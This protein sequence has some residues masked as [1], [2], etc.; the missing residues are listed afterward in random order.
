[1]GVVYMARNK[2]NG[3]AYVGITTYGFKRRMDRHLAA[4]DKGEHYRFADAIRKYGKDAWDWF[5][6][7]ESNDRNLLC[8]KEIEFIAQYGYYNATLG[9]DG[10]FGL[11]PS[12]ETKAKISAT[13]K[14][15][16]HSEER[17]RHIGD[18]QRGKPK[19]S[20]SEAT[21]EKIGNANR[22][23]KLPPIS[24][25]TREKMRAAMKNRVFS[26][27][28]CAKISAAKLAKKHQMPL[29]VKLKISAAKIGVKMPPDVKI[30]ISE[31]MREFWKRRKKEKIDAEL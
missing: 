10:A 1:M 2:I 29:D 17:R 14:G 8:Q 12:A 19:R 26:D 23:R 30:K 11:H 21:K 15:R 28:H 20:M 27:E 18:A 24:Q 31:G 22:G 9:G 5:V 4:A 16:P 13:L 6:L 3:H 25:E 7:F